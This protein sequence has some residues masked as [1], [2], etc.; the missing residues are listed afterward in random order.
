MNFNIQAVTAA[1]ILSLGLVET[2]QANY[3]E[4]LSET[5]ESGATFNGIV[6]FDNN[7]DALAV[8]GTLSGYALGTAGYVGGS[9]NESISWV[10]D[11]TFDYA[12]APL[13]SNFLLDADPASYDATINNS[14]V[15]T[16][17]FTNAS[18]PVFTSNAFDNGINS[19]SSNWDALVSGTV[20]AVPEPALFW[21]FA[22]GIPYISWVGRRKTTA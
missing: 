22:S 6:T 10:F 8:S 4:A 12:T 18:A 17:D 19:G 1:L 11:P 13:A 15:F 3:I 7:F 21:L 5:F 20:T 16:I 2:V 14:L 9:A